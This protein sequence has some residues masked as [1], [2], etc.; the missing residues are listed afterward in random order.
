MKLVLLSLVI[1]LLSV[2]HVRGQDLAVAFTSKE[3]GIYN[4]FD[5]GG[6]STFSAGKNFWRHR[7]H[8]VATKIGLVTMGAG[9]ACAIAG[10]YINNNDGPGKVPG[11][12]ITYKQ[13]GTNLVV[14]GGAVFVTGGLEYILGRVYEKRHS[15]IFY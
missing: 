7:K 14:I 4:N 1:V 2:A 10:I 3:A 6:V 5:A 11:K 9:V 15:E 8:C 12:T 13:E